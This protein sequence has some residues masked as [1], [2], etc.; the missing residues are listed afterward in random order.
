MAG[1]FVVRGGWTDLALC[2]GSIESSDNRLCQKVSKGR[3]AFL[4]KK[5]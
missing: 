1:I 4:L 3:F 2:L 5:I